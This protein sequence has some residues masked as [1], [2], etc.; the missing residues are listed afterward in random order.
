MSWMNFLPRTGP[1]IGSGSIKLFLARSDELHSAGYT[2][3]GLVGRPVRAAC[4]CGFHKAYLVLN[5]SKN[6][7]PYSG[8][9]RDR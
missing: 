7:N 6:Y 8:R 2:V 5:L 1:A 4:P 3:V 9:N